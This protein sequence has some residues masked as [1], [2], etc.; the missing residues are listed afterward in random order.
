[1]KAKAE[2]TTFIFG[3]IFGFLNQLIS[4]SPGAYLSIQGISG[5]CSIYRIEFRASRDVVVS[6]VLENCGEKED[7]PL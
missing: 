2:Y 1:M 5:L 7:R 6:G 3:Q 4:I